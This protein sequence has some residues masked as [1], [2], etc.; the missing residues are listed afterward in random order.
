MGMGSFGGKG[1][2]G[3]AAEI[4][5]TPL[6]DVML[7]LLIIF[8]VSAPMMTQGIDI[9][10]PKT[11]GE[12]LEQQ[13]EPLSVKI[14][15]DGQLFFEKNPAPLSAAALRHELENLPPE[16]RQEPIY[17]EADRDVP[18][19]AVVQVMALIKQVGFEQLGMVTQE[20]DENS[21]GDGRQ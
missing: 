14:N 7:V 15:S 20:S 10:L 17:L 11:T 2:K 6:V 4:N 9:N 1:R 21:A 3:L 13:Q 12:A 8:M 5:V 19:G 16:K 18:Y